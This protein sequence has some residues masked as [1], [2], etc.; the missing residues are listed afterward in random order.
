AG[1][2]AVRGGAGR[3]RRSAFVARAELPLVCVMDAEP[4]RAARPPLPERVVARGPGRL[5]P[6][7]V[8]SGPGAARPGAPARVP[9]ADA[10]APARYALLD[11]ESRARPH[12]A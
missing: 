10:G 3:T 12:R 1:R 7:A 4:P 9:S 8:R 6:D 11:L 5:P 2:E